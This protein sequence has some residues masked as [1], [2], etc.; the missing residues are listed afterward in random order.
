MHTDTIEKLLEAAATVS[1][2]EI[3]EYQ[4]NAGFTSGAFD[5]L[6]ADAC[7]PYAFE[8]LDRLCERI[9]ALIGSGSE[10]NGYYFLL[11]QLAPRTGTTEMPFGMQR[12]ID[13][14]PLLSRDLR[15]WYR[16]GR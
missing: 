11:N 1:R 4:H 13:A 16:C 8:L 12:I 10:L 15:I 7:G 3:P 5:L 14:D 6:L 9:A 2:G